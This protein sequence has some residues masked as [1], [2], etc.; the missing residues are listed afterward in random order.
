MSN[1]NKR[2]FTIEE[3]EKIYDIKIKDGI[4]TAGRFLDYL[5]TLSSTPEPTKEECECPCHSWG[6]NSICSECGGKSSPTEVP[7]EDICH[8]PAMENPHLHK[9]SLEVVSDGKRTD[10]HPEKECKHRM[11]FDNDIHEWK[12]YEC[13]V[14][15]VSK[16]QPLPEIATLK[17]IP[18]YDGDIHGWSL[19]ILGEMGKCYVKVNELVRTVNK[20]TQ[21]EQ[22]EHE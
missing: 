20:L 1:P 6:I 17:D 15:A 3:L 16:S 21:R 14:V 4:M 11:Y 9:S 13:G 18:A 7:E 19:F 12:C 22:E 2:A 8:C 10:V 5:R